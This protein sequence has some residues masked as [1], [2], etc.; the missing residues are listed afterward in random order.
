MSRL[1]LARRLTQL[2]FVALLL[3]APAFDIFRYDVAG[4]DLYVLGHVWSLGLGPEFYD[5]PG[6]VGGGRVALMFLLHAVLPW[7]AALAVFPLLGFLLGRAFCGW[8]C[9][10]GALFEFADFLTLRLT[11]RRSIYAPAPNDPPGMRG[12][13]WLW[14]SLTLVYLLTVPPL[15]GVMLTGYFIA[16]SRIWAELLSLNPSPGLRY[17]VVGVSLYML[18]TFLFVRHA[19]C[20]YL[21]GAGLMQ[22]LFGW[23]SPLS[24]GIGF[25]GYEGCTDCRGCERACFMGV[26]PR[27]G[28]R[29]IN[30]VNCGECV[31]ACRKELGPNDGL[32]SFGFGRKGSGERR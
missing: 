4:K 11:G 22:M 27:S 23:V 32:F 8:A 15:F 29:E 17:G 2:G 18:L 26:R 6:A 20:K 28:R 10:E 30:C 24:L 19:I 5:S 7:V 1:R 16:P 21:C 25:R 3:L 12:S 31:E 14:G 9:P 13:T